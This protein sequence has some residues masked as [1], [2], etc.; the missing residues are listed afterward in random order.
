MRG[1]FFIVLIATVLFAVAHWYIRTADEC[2]V[3]IHYRLGSYDERFLL[4]PDEVKEV[5]AQAETAWEM[6]L[7]RELFVYDDDA[8]F[9]VD[10]VFDERQRQAMSEEEFREQL[11][12]Q[13]RRTSE[14]KAKVDSITAQYETLKGRYEE[15]VR[16]YNTRLARYNAEVESINA[17]GGATPREQE[18]LKKEQTAIATEQS[19][20]EEMTEDL[21]TLVE[22]LNALGEEGNELI[23]GYNNNVA[24]YN[25]QYGEAGAF[26]Q[27][28]Y[29][30]K[31]ITIYKYSNTVELRHVMAHEF[32]HALGL[33]HVEDATAIMYYL[34]EQQPDELTLASQDV[35]ALRLVCGEGETTS[36]HLRRMIRTLLSLFT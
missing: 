2:P 17:A 20:L 25:D 8:S 27:G 32:G 34:L 1:S 13:E 26:T 12:E 30:G 23:K 4:P 10:F 18:R 21:Y 33:D 29:A 11:N 22:E 15:R 19:A 36:Q 5:I 6:A 16:A 3:P 24:V 9:V 14:T 28:E 35:A 7:G 31:Q